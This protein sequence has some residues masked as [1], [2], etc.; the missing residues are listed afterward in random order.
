MLTLK[1][2]ICVFQD[3]DDG[4]LHILDN[5][6]IPDIISATSSEE[7]L[8]DRVRNAFGESPVLHE[9]STCT[10]FKT[11]VKLFDWFSSHPSISKEAFSRNLKLWHYI[12]PKGNC[13][14][15]SYREAYNIMKPYLVP[16]V[17]FHVCPNDCIVF[18]GEYKN[19]VTCPKCQESRYKSGKVNIPQRT[20][21]YLPL[22]P[23]LARSF[24]TEDIS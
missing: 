11:L 19:S 24:G 8:H 5:S 14:P 12:L 6:D 15:V 23:R 1:L 20:F 4:E 3:S 9:G 2:F 18:R 17:V 7:P 22:G 16:E 21:H 13:L 10:L